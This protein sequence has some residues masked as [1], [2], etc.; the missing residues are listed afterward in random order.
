MKGRMATL[1]LLIGLLFATGA[2]AETL[3]WCKVLG[4]PSNQCGHCVAVEPDRW[5]AVPKLT[6]EQIEG[7]DRPLVDRDPFIRGERWR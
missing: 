5:G 3:D 4:V 1:G 2:T 6:R 7:A